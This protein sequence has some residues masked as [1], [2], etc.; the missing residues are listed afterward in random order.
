ME[1]HWRWASLLGAQALGCRAAGSTFM[2]A[3][4]FSGPLTCPAL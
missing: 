1:K 4:S 3:V 2:W